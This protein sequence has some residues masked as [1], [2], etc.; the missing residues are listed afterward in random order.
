MKWEVTHTIVHTVEA[1][2]EDAAI[3]WSYTELDDE[4]WHRYADSV[5]SSAREVTPVVLILHIN[6]APRE[7][8]F[9]SRAEAEDWVN[10]FRPTI[11]HTIKNA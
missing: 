6:D 9:S 7:I 2:T 3:E 4:Y 8:P 5:S 10:H 1:E 11:R